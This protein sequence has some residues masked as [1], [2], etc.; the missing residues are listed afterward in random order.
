MTS[1]GHGTLAL[2]DIDLG[3][4]GGLVRCNQCQIAP[5][6]FSQQIQPTRFPLNSQRIDAALRQGPAR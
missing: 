4:L 2:L 1:S 3:N 6:R 5:R